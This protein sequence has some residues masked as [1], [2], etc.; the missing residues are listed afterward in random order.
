MASVPMDVRQVARCRELAAEIAADVQRYIDAHTTVGVERTV[1]RAYGAEGIDDQGVPLVNLAVDRYRQAGLLGRGIAFFLARAL[2]AGASTVQ[3]AAERLAFSPDLDRGEGPPGPGVA[4]DALAP[5]TR[6]AIARIDA[7][8]EEREAVKRRFPPVPT[9]QKYVIVATGNIHDDA[10]QAKA[11]AYAGADIIAVIRATAQSL[12]DYVPHGATTEGYGGTFATQENFRIIRRALDEASAA[13][14]RYVQQTNYSSGLCMAEIA[15][16]A[17]VERLDM[18]LNDAMYGIL[19]R[20]INMCRTFVDQYVSRRFIARAGIVINTGE[21]NYLTTA[22]AVQKAHTV[23]ASQFINEALALR[24]G[25]R[26]E[27]MGLGH[28]YEIDPWLEDSFLLEIA[29]AQLVRQIFDRHPIKWMPP[30]KHKTGDVFFAH[31]HDAMFDLVGVTTRQ[32][33]E[34]LGMFSE[35]IHNPLLMDRYLALKATRYVYGACKHLGDEIEFKRDGIV[36]RRAEAVLAEALA[37]LEEVARESIWEAIGR[38]AF[39]DVKRA[40]TGGKGFAGVVDRASDY[41]NPLLD[42]L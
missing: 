25:L 33:I 32:S 7:A 29:Q 10:V 9:P 42:A 26:E 23:L 37:L 21:D 14:G 19:F 38:G 39:A 2:A 28:A 13:Q 27:Q 8:R 36:A 35:A 6:A 1:L 31:V 12:L 18:L 3:D 4:R 30:T 16:M 5:H 15:W 24:A 41:T 40:R 11:A 17:A 20:D 34:L 22:D